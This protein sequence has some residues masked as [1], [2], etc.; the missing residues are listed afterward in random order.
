MSDASHEIRPLRGIEELRACVALQEETWGHGFSERV[1]PSLLKVAQL[2]G[3]VTAGAFDEDGRLDAF[4]FGLT[5]V[6]DGELVHWSD[7]MAVR[8]GV[9]DRGLGTRLK[10]HQRSVLLERGIRTVLWTVDPLQARNAHLGFAKLG[11]IVREYVRD[12]YGQSDSP[13]HRG[14]GTDRFVALWQ[15]DS[16]RV[17]ERLEKGRAP[18]A[19]LPYDIPAALDVRL[20]RVLP[21]PDEVRLNLDGDH[22]TVA[23]PGDISEIMAESMELALAWREA[24]RTAF[25]HYLERGYEVIELLRNER[26]ARYLLARAS[27]GLGPEMSG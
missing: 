6:R 17:T 8:R 10:R 14:I 1:P 3:G 23:I 2:V 13:L 9:R 16:P 19:G 11:I 24:T 5:G 22:L 18:E 26:I 4:V 25:L 21:E 15:L 27:D 20:N 12:M 7:M